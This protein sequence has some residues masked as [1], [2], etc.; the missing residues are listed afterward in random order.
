MTTLPTDC[1]SSGSFRPVAPAIGVKFAQYGFGLPPPGNAGVFS[2]LPADAAI[3]PLDAGNRQAVARLDDDVLRLGV[4]LGIGG[5]EAFDLLARLRNRDAVGAWRNLR[6]LRALNRRA[7]IDEGADR[8]T[9]RELDQ[10]ADVIDVV[11]GRD[12]VIDLFHPGVG[13]RGHDPVEIRAP[14]NP[15]SMIA[16]CPVGVT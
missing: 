8:N 12:E 3:P 14:G 13:D 16:V 15:V 4:E 1:A 7:V 9:L 2:T 6:H 10:V 11:M 5:L